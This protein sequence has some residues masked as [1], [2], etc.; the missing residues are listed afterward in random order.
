MIDVKEL[1]V[2]YDEVCAVQ[3]VSL[4]VQPGEVFGLIG[5]N[6]AGK[7][8]TLRALVGL[9]EPTYG[10]IQLGEFNLETEPA[11]ALCQ[12]GFM[13][14]YT[15]IYDDITV[16][17]FLDM[18][19]AS[20]NIP[21]EERERR[22]TEYLGMVDIS[23]KRDTMTKGLS[24]GMKQRL[25]LARTLIPQPKIVLLDE[26]ASGMDPFGRAMLKQ[27]IRELRE[28]GCAVIVSS[29]ILSELSEFCDTVGIMEK[30]RIVMS[31]E[32]QEI[33]R[34]V[35]GKQ[36]VSMELLSDIAVCQEILQTITDVS[37]V[38]AL[39]KSV[40]FE[41]N[42]DDAQLS[43]LLALL[44]SQGVQVISFGKQETDLESIFL[45]VGAREVS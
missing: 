35:F 10:S 29:H 9:L 3:D 1:R 26:P 33:G 19:A 5:P 12:V 22:I 44:M 30:G 24:R 34:Q 16:W 23:V 36:R 2:D 37:A 43:Q 41:F 40:S 25:M 11:E 42:G 27:V 28:Q 20:Y 32:V 17:E 38:T 8:T 31:G 18:F 21:V 39:E 45:Q 6:G 7:T 4:H 14:D 13:P 15:P